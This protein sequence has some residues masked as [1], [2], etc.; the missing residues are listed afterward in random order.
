MVALRHAK[1]KLVL[2]V[3]LQQPAQPM[4]VTKYV[5]MVQITEPSSATMEIHTTMMVAALPATLK[6][7]GTVMVVPRPEQTHVMKNVV[8]EE[9]SINLELILAMMVIMMTGMVA[10]LIVILKMDTLAQEVPLQVPTSVMKFVVMD[11]V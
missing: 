2:N 10:H 8:M 11:T 1:L 9:T 4:T 6:M 7:V 5:V 3:I